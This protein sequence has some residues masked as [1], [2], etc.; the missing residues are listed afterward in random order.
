MKIANHMMEGVHFHRSPNMGAIIQPRFIVMHYTAGWT[1]S[2]AISTLTNPKSGVSAHFVVDRDGSV[3]QLVPCNRAA[4][5]AGPSAYKGYKNLNSHSVGIEIVNP[6]YLRKGPGEQILDWDKK[7]VSKAKL[8]GYDLSFEA[9]HAR[10]GGG[11]FVWPKYTEAQYSTLR[12]LVAALEAAYDIDDVVT[13][14]E[15]DT[16]GWKTDPGPAFELR[17]FK[18]MVHNK[19]GERRD[20]TPLLGTAQTT[21]RLNVRASPNGMILTTLPLGAYVA[22]IKDAGDWCLVNYA[23]GKQGYVSQNYL[24]K[25]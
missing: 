16:R 19:A 25:V 18:D 13:H 5:H 22:V 7:P 15:I 20:D 23:P 2:S 21:A 10:I 11:I 9:P 8:M 14:E 6:G 24:R 4:W 12:K 1:A 17:Q 3:T